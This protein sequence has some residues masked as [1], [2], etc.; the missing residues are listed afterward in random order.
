MR[1]YRDQADLL[2]ETLNEKRHRLIIRRAAAK[3]NG[4]ETYPFNKAIER[5]NGVLDELRRTMDDMGWP[6]GSA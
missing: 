1:L 4:D 6:H 5:V 3:Q 2:L